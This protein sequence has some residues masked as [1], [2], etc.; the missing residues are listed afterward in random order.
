MRDWFDDEGRLV[1]DL[2]VTDVRR[3]CFVDISC[4][5]HVDGKSVLIVIMSGM[6]PWIRDTRM[7]IHARKGEDIQSDRWC[8]LPSL[9]ME[10]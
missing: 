9:K 5:V 2:F 10:S 6:I 8:H 3:Q 1:S 4:V 7:W